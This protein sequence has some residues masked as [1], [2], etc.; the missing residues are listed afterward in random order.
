MPKNAPLAPKASGPAIAP[1]AEEPSALA[2]GSMI[3]QPVAMLQALDKITARVRRLPI[4]VGDTVKFGTLAVQVEACRKAPPEDSPEAAAFLKITDGKADKPRTVFTGWM[5]ASS[6][7]LSAMDDPV[8]DIWVV[9]CTSD[10]TS[11]LCGRFTI[12]TSPINLH[13]VWPGSWAQTPSPRSR[14]SSC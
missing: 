5:F 11:V 14:A 7:A 2:P 6:P 9:D 3:D 1:P 10:W 4:K 12:I 13:R 8:Y